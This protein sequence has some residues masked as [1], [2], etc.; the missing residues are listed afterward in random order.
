[1]AS[2]IFFHSHLIILERKKTNSTFKFS[3]TLHK[4]AKKADRANKY[5]A[6]LCQ[7]A[8][9]I[10]QLQQFPGASSIPAINS[11][12]AKTR[13]QLSGF[14]KSISIKP[15][16]SSIFYHQGREEEHRKAGSKNE[17]EISKSLVQAQLLHQLTYL[18]KELLAWEK[19][20]LELR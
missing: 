9:I 18:W 3:Q 5:T 11:P 7:H 6:Y 19:G 14:L 12:G 10:S 8:S 2:Q 1:M 16:S 4:H 17:L 15:S 20:R 13:W